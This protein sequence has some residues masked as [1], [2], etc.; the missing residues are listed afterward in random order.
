MRLHYAMHQNEALLQTQMGHESKEELHRH[1][2]AI[3]TRAEAG[4]FWKLMPLK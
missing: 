4:R 2:R 3:T 1:Y